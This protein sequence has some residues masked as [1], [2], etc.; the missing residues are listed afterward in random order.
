MQHLLFYSCK[1]FR[2][3]VGAV[4]PGHVKSLSDNYL[5]LSFTELT[6]Y[7]DKVMK[8][9]A[10]V[11]KS[12]GDKRLVWLLERGIQFDG[13][14]YMTEPQF[15]AKYR[16]KYKVLPHLGLS[17]FLRKA[18]MVR[19][20]PIQA[21]RNYTADVTLRKGSPGSSSLPVVVKKTDVEVDY[22]FLTKELGQKVGKNQSWMAK[23]ST[24]L[25]L[26]GD[27]RYHQ[28][29]R[30]GKSSLIH[31]YSQSALDAVQKKLASEPAFN[32]YKP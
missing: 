22:P 25:G 14:Q 7:A 12:A 5:S 19:I 27:P 3:V 18:E 24:V 2:E 1:F 9:V 32:P 10:R 30:A 26:K 8:S 20:V 29:V 17:A 23:A 4:F 28:A 13:S 21:P 16:G 11:R 15:E 6:T 31:R